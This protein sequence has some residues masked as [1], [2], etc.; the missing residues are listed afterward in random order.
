MILAGQGVNYQHYRPLRDLATMVPVSL[1]IFIAQCLIVSSGAWFHRRSL[2]ATVMQPFHPLEIITGLLLLLMTGA[3]VSRDSMAYLQELPL[4]FTVQI[5]N[6]V[7]LIIG[8]INIPA[9]VLSKTRDYWKRLSG[10][11]TAKIDRVVLVSAGMVTVL[12]AALCILSY[13]RHP[14]LKDEVAYYFHARY[15]AT[16]RLYLPLPPVIQ[17]YNFELMDYDAT[18]WYAS[19]PHGWPLMLALGII[20]GVPW[21]VNPVL[22]GLN[23]VLIY[24]LVRDLYDRQTAR[25]SALLLSFSPWHILLAMSFMTHIAALTFTLLAAIAVSRARRRESLLWAFIGGISTGM[26]GMIRPLEGMIVAGLTGIWA[27]TGGSVKRRLTRIG[28]WAAGCS[29]IGAAILHYNQTLTGKAT[30]FPIMA[31][32]DKYFGPN[33]NAMGFGPD[34]GLGWALDPYPGHG[35]RD[36][37]VNSN[38]NITALNTELFGWS[39]GSII[40]LMMILL[41]R[42]VKGKDY[43]LLSL[44]ALIFTAHVFYWFS[45]GPDFGARYWFLMIISCVVLTT[46]GINEVIERISR[47]TSDDCQIRVYVL[48]G[49]LCI[50]SL[51]T[52]IPWR[53]VDKYYHYLGMRPDILRLADEHRFGRSLVLIRGRNFPDY[54]SA[55]AYN[56]LDMIGGETIYAL[57]ENENIHAEL[58]RKYSDRPIWIVEGPSVT[59]RGY[60]I[61]AGPVSAAKLTAKGRE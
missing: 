26:V 60:K 27:I 35:I 58:L 30:T 40:F 43:Y 15:L 51:I 28:A 5:V 41:M 24:I 22:G 31:W 18:R 33:S 10:S 29:L 36:V 17:A 1:A 50:M 46:R 11:E 32:A 39:T 16:G 52:F 3:T 55:A 54:S 45:G 47:S 44:L 25:I 37:I 34:R 53:A 2:R 56:P 21:L 20:L 12:A 49:V 57:D 38:L 59:Q 7:N 4:A 19:P 6:L 42:K 61:I 23:I 48:V 13:Q 14:H 8:A 9:G